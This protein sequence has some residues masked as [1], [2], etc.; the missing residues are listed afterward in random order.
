MDNLDGLRDIHLPAEGVPFFPPA[1]GWWGLLALLIAAAMMV[2]LVRSVR[3]TS[4]KMYALN[5]L[6]P[7]KNQMSLAAVVKMSEILRRVC[8]YKYPDAVSLFGDDW[9]DFL[10]SKSKNKMDGETAELLKNAPFMRKL[11]DWYDGGIQ[12]SLWQYCYDWTGENL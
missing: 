9:I 8:I 6:E 12:Q 4:T 11:P 1:I 2:H 3:K 10:N 5:L 7:L